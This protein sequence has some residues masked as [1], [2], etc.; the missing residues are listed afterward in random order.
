M[1][2]PHFIIGYPGTSKI[3]Y[4]FTNV[5]SLLQISRKL[6]DETAAKERERERWLVVKS[7]EPFAARRDKNRD[8]A[9]LDVEG[10]E[11]SEGREYCQFLGNRTS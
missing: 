7:T 10:G 8:G 5:P 9:I 2:D 6:V 4:G 1:R 11:V 3:H